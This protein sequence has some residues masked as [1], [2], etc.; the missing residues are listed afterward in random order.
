MKTCAL[1]VGVTCQQGLRDKSK[2]L[3]KLL[4]WYTQIFRYNTEDDSHQAW[5]STLFTLVLSNKFDQIVIFGISKDHIIFIYLDL[6]SLLK[7]C[8]SGWYKPLFFEMKTDLLNGKYFGPYDF[9]RKRWC[10][11]NNILSYQLVSELLKYLY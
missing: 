2:I 9:L 5:P 1:W 6:Y 3:C 7:K 4:R 10:L 8:S 11:S